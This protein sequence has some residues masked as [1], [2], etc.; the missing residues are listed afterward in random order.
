[1]TTTN[2]TEAARALSYLGLP[3]DYSPSPSNEPIPFLSLH[4]H[5]LPPELLSI[6]SS[7]TTARERSTVPTIRNRRFRY[8]Q[9]NPSELKLSNAKRSWP[10]LWEG[11]PEPPTSLGKD[12][13]KEE[14]DW[15]ERDFLGGNSAGPSGEKRNHV[16]KLGSL[17]GGYEEDREVERMRG[18]RRE[19]AAKAA[20][21]FVPEEDESSEDGDGE[22]MGPSRMEERSNVGGGPPQND[23]MEE[24]QGLFDRRVRERFIYGLL[25]VF[26]P[27]SLLWFYADIHLSII[28]LKRGHL[29]P[30]L[31]SDLYDIV[32]WD[33]RWDGDDQ[34]AQDRWFDD[35]D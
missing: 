17:L 26:L 33:E 28:L 3:S 7:L 9:S 8:T 5:Q 27:I 35:D 24:M 34:D 1:M 22:E 10:A 23:S 12:S 25:Q 18:V 29:L 15:V 11:P 21:E 2:T 20:E 19:M 32:D 4:I 16:G 14:H 6:F 30:V 13:A 31:Q